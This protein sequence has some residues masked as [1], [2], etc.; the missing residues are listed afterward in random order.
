MGKDSNYDFL[1]GTG[2]FTQ[3]H[4]QGNQNFLLFIFQNR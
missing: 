2:L 1:E 3:H 4:D